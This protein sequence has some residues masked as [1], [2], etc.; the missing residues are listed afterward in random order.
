MKK[1]ELGEM[2]ALIFLVSLFFKE[3]LRQAKGDPWQM[4]TVLVNNI[5]SGLTPYFTDP[6]L[7]E[8]VLTHLLTA[9][10]STVIIL[11]IF[12]LIKAIGRKRNNFNNLF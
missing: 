5:V 8:R 2:L 12:C 1:L 11:L 4:G 3:I 7:R 10:T 6:F 9:V